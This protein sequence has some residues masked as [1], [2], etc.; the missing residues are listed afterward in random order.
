MITISSIEKKLGF[1]PMNFHID[2]PSHNSYD[3]EE[4]PFSKLSHE[5]L[6]FLINYLASRRKATA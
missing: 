1:D 5:E 3:D 4:N 6:D 2:N